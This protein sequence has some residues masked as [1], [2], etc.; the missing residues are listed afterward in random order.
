MPNLITPKQLFKTLKGKIHPEIDE[1][2]KNLVDIVNSK[3]KQW[4]QNQSQNTLIQSL[5]SNSRSPNSITIDKL[6]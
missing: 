6:L 4:E 3:I 5:S 1:L 2:V